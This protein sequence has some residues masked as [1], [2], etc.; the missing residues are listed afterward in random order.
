MYK[1]GQVQSI[2]KEDTSS[3]FNFQIEGR[4]YFVLLSPTGSLCS[5][6]KA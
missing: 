1:R 6:E 2:F 5:G 3:P 4:G